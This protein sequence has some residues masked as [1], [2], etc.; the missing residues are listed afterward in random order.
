ML[1]CLLLEIKLVDFTIRFFGNN[2]MLIIGMSSFNSLVSSRKGKVDLIGYL[3]TTFIHYTHYH[4][5]LGR[6][7]DKQRYDPLKYF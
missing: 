7:G 3:V 5:S 4:T 1:V 2:N 6:S